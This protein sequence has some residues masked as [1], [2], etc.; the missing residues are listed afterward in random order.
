MSNVQKFNVTLKSGVVAEL[1]M[2]IFDVDTTKGMVNLTKIAKACERELSDWLRLSS[3]KESIDIWVEEKGDLQKVQVAVKGGDLGETEQGTWVIRELA[4]DYAQ[5]I[6]PRFKVWC[7]K[8]LDELFQTGKVELKPMTQEEMLL[9]V[10][11][12]L[13]A[14]VAEQKAIAQEAIRT[15][16][17]ISDKKVASALNT[18]SQA[19]KKVNK[20]EIELDRSK[21]YRTIK[22]ME[23]RHKGYKFDWR[24]L[25]KESVKQGLAII[26]VFDANYGEVSSYHKEVWQNCYGIDITSY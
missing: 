19:V 7:T 1:D 15:K 24:P 12:T 20:L 25:K 21:E 9:N 2:S 14:Q 6:S 18:A 17:Y 8:A 26:K 11:T 13:Q 4:L 10:L 3:V 23:L 5:Y 16:A 22:G